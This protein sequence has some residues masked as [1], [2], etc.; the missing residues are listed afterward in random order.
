M[1]ET[2][3]IP[4][5]PKPVDLTRAALLVLDARQQT[6][7]GLDALEHLVPIVGDMVTE[8]GALRET[9]TAYREDLEDMRAQV[10]LSQSMRLEWASIHVAL[11]LEVHTPARMIA[12]LESLDWSKNRTRPGVEIWENG[13]DREYACV[14]VPLDEAFSDYGG[15]MAAAVRT[16]ATALGTGELGV[17]A[18]IAEVGNG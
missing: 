9:V 8:I 14:R 1:T 4:G 12:F 2:T 5:A 7:A 11:N 10:E 18:A 6:A 16:L 3:T 15:V 13:R 17:L